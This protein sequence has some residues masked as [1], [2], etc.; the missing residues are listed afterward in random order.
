[1]AGAWQK[2]MQDDSE[3]YNWLRSNTK[4]CPQCGKAT[5]KNGGCNHISCT[6]G[7]HWCWMCNKNFN[8]STVY[9]HA[10]NAFDDK[11]AFSADHVQQ[12]RGVLERYLHYYTRYENHHKSKKIE[13]TLSEKMKIK[14]ERLTTLDKTNPS[15][16]DQVGDF[17]LHFG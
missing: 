3:T 14:M 4:D 1:M 13:S 12:A 2:K 10:C 11:D 6:C 9:N 8:T 17:F 7:A 15:Y 16:I 5:E